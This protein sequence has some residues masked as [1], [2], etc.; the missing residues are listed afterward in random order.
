[1]L[2]STTLALTLILALTGADA[3]LACS[4][5]PSPPPQEALQ[6]AGA[7]FTG[8]VVAVDT[9]GLSSTVR[10]RVEKGWKGAKCGEV[11]V[12]TSADSA[13]CGYDFQV[14]QSYLVYADKQKGK[15]NVSLCSRTSLTSQAGEDLAA[16]GEPATT[17]PAQ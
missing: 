13:A 8:T 15:L 14:G 9:S 12:V 11:T 17:C 4:C 5:A 7:V 10:L 16:L 3:A 1:M 2:R 6:Q